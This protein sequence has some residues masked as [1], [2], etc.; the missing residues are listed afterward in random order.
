M[1]NYV[2]NDLRIEIFNEYW[3]WLRDYIVVVGF[4]FFK[5]IL[6]ENGNED[7]NKFWRVIFCIIINVD[8]KI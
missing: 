5:F 1:F 3:K 2:L 7:K 6:D 4:F 8:S